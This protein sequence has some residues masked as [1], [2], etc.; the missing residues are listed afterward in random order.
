M[1]IKS[2][3]LSSQLERIIR[4]NI[5]AFDVFA[6]E[7]AD[8]AAI[9]ALDEIKTVISAELS[10]PDTVERIV[11]ILKKHNIDTQTDHNAFYLLDKAAKESGNKSKAR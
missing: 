8:S 1:N 9:R 3:L 2:E 6:D 11:N 7:I 5:E 4:E 10:D